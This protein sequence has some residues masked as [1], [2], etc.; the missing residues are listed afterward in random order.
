LKRNEKRRKDILNNFQEEQED[1]DFIDDK[2]VEDVVEE[3]ESYKV[4][5]ETIDT[6]ST[7]D[8]EENV[9]DNWTAQELQ[10]AKRYLD[11]AGKQ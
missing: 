9:F 8:D 6:D 1:A 7:E 11:E 3:A 5:K 2:G 10:W 4:I